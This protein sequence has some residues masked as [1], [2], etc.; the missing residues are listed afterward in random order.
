MGDRCV[1][2]LPSAGLFDGDG[3]PTAWAVYIVKVS[4]VE[5]LSYAETGFWMTAVFDEWSHE[6]T[7]P[8]NN[9]VLRLHEIGENLWFSIDYTQAQKCKICKAVS[10]RIIPLP[11]TRF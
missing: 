3:C 9:E 4:D 8:E 5:G 10:G 7:N 1:Q 2:E 6:M 11:F